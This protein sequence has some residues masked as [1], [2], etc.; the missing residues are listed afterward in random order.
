MASSGIPMSMISQYLNPS[1][2]SFTQAAS[3]MSMASSPE[4]YGGSFLN[5]NA[6]A[7][8]EVPEPATVLVCLAAIA[9]IGIRRHA[10]FWRSRTAC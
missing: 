8:A 1:A 10:R 9:G 2:Y 4:L 6:S 5:I 3:G 7:G